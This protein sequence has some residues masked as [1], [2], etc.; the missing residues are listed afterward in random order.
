MSCDLQELI[1]KTTMECLDRGRREENERIVKAL[2]A[3]KYP[4]GIN[5]TYYFNKGVD[6]ALGIVKGEIK[7]KVE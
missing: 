7:G 5:N 4:N 6:W 3:A 1:H 2:E